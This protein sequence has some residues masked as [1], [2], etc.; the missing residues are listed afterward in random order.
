MN[1]TLPVLI[2]FQPLD[3]RE[4]RKRGTIGWYWWWRWWWRK[5]FVR[6]QVPCGIAENRCTCL[7]NTNKNGKP[8]IMSGEKHDA[9]PGCFKLI[10]REK[11]PA[12]CPVTASLLLSPPPPCLFSPFNVSK[13]PRTWIDFYLP[14]R[15][16]ILGLSRYFKKMYS[17]S[18][19]R[20][21]CI[22]IYRCIIAI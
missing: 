5:V 4:I 12:L 20:V 3:E 11:S 10:F 19:F 7:V 18:L 17:Q 2:G 14:V 6:F 1:S 16:R 8:A 21:A 13:M 9:Y 15:I 22:A